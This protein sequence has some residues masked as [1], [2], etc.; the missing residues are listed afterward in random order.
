MLR[1]FAIEETKKCSCN[2]LQI[3]KKELL[4]FKK[5]QPCE[6]F[7]E[8][9]I[10]SRHW[11]YDHEPT[12]QAHHIKNRILS[13]TNT[14][15]EPS[16]NLE[17]QQENIVVLMSRKRV[18]Y[19]PTVLHPNHFITHNFITMSKEEECKD[20]YVIVPQEEY[21]KL[22]N[23]QYAELTTLKKK[24][25]PEECHNTYLEATHKKHYPAGV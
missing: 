15:N 22:Y 4:R 14:I 10:F 16:S 23:R 3:S 18:I 2:C 8:D 5:R 24:V 1:F 17:N 6:T 13:L 20:G 21:A 7:K 25:D 9:L 12:D 19:N 11:P